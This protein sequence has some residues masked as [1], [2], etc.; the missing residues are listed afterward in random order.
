MKSKSTYIKKIKSFDELLKSITFLRLNFGWSREYAKKIF[1]SLVKD[2]NKIDFYGFSLNE[3]EGGIVGVILTLYQGIFVHD[4]KEIIM[5]NLSSWYVLKKYR[6]YHAI[7]M[8]KKINKELCNFVITNFSPNKNAQAILKA[9]GFKQLQTCTKNFYIYKF[10]IN[11]F[12][13]LRFK[14]VLEYKNKHINLSLDKKINYRDSTYI[15]LRIKDNVLILLITESH[16]VRNFRF[17][18]KLNLKVSRLHILWSS[19]N[20]LFKDNFSSILSFLFCKYKTFMISNHCLNSKYLREKKIWRNH[21]YKFSTPI[22]N[23]LFLAGSEYS[24]KF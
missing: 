7:F 3:D 8:L 6:G 23:D 14:R 4:G 5:I 21:F 2:K 20:Y 17:I 13:E 11:I 24:V 19:D 15:R 10:F 18:N 12:N 22:E 9:V 16:L 1:D